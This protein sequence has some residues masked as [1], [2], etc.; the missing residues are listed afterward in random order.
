MRVTSALGAEGRYYDILFYNPGT[1]SLDIETRGGWR[2]NEQP[3]QQ[4]VCDCD[5]RFIDSW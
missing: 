3:V 5:S 2:L 1:V 4:K